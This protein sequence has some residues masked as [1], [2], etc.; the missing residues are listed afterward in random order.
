MTIEHKLG[1]VHPL[2]LHVAELVRKLSLTTTLYGREL[3]HNMANSDTL[4]VEQVIRLAAKCDQHLPTRTRTGMTLSMIGWLPIEADIRKR[5]LSL[6]QKLCTLSPTLLSRKL[7][8]YRLNL[9]VVR[10]QIGF[11]PDVL[12][13]LAKYGLV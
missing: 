6:L 13:I 4:K 9:F 3:L 2:V 8:N 7:C 12:K 10:D 1:D 5:K 11:V